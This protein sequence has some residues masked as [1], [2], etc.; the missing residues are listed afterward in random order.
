MQYPTGLH[1]NVTPA[2]YFVIDQLVYDIKACFMD[3]RADP[4]LNHTEDTA[5]YGMNEKIPNK[6]FLNKMITTALGSMIDTHED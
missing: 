2:N 1:F 5:M 4:S 3:M 6:M